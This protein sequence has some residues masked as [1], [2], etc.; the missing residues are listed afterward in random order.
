MLTLTS[1]E[2]ARKLINKGVLAVDDGIE[3]AFDGFSIEANIVCHNIS[4][5]DY[6][7]NIDC[8]D[9]DCMDIDCTDINCRNIDCTD[10]NCRNIDCWDI[11]CTDIN[12]RNIDC[13][14]INC[15]DINCMDINYYAVCFACNN[16][17]CKS[18]AGRRVNSKHFC[19]GGG[20]IFKDDE[21]VKEITTEQATRDL[22]DKYPNGVK[23][24]VD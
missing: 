10:I 11:D 2:Q 23:I 20:I 7:R 21:E 17:K 1:N 13:T 18:I 3:I 14:D 16:I 24:K 4:S 5:K 22:K 12:C 19:L 9:I 15:R 6:R 8:W